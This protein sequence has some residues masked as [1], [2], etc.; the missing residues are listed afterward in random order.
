MDVNNEAHDFTP[1]SG[2]SQTATFYVIILVLAVLNIKIT[3]LW[4]VTTC[5][6]VCKC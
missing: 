6:V 3:V 1:I 4:Y 2:L 5:N